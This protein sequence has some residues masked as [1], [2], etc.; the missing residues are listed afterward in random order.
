MKKKIGLIIGRFQ[1]FH[2]GHRYLFKKSLQSVDLLIIG[3]GSVN[4]TGDDNPLNYQQ[5]KKLLKTVIIKENLN[6]KILKIVPLSD[7]RSDD[8][9]F[10]NT[11]K[12][13]GKIDMIIGNN[14]WT[15]NIF[16]SKGYPICRIGYYKRYLYEGER[17]RELIKKKK[18][19][20]NRVPVYLVETIKKHLL[21]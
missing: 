18:P 9:W 20:Q 4:S 11:I 6:K 19:W 5:R 2:N 14:E 16:K 3:I 13:T 7:Y 10:I 17:I 12:K 8:D 21:N 1:P 15:N